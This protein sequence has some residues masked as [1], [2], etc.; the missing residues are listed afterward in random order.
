ERRDFLPPLIHTIA[1]LGCPVYVEGGIGS[2]MGYV[3]RDY[4]SHTGVEIVDERTAYEQDVVIVLR[5]PE[6][7]FEFAHPGATLLSMLHFPTRPARVQQLDRLGINAISLDTIV[8]DEGRRLVVNG[9][10]VAWNG[11]DAAFEQ[12]ERTWPSMFDTRRRPVRVTVMGAGDIGKHAVEAATKYGNL[13]RNAAYATRGMPGVEVVTVGRNLT[14]DM[15]YMHERLSAT[16]VLVDATQRDDPARPLLSNDEVGLLPEHAV[17]CDLVVDPYLLDVDPPTV[18]G[19]EGIPQGSLDQYTFAID[20]PA[21]NRLPPGIATAARRTVVSCYSWPGIHPA[22]CM[23]HYGLQLEPLLETLIARG[24]FEGIRRDGTCSERA[25][26][27]GS[28]RAW[29]ASQPA[30]SRVSHSE[31][32]STGR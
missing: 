30:P 27:R 18:R 4:E 19:I 15:P 9:K 11:L 29:L 6:G 1:D 23:E 22:E 32:V 10:A 3:D 8:D 14:A 25:L 24:G 28:L 5:A 7:R 12:L 2:G 13:E 16:D 31:L 21:W 17:I 20:D 26:W